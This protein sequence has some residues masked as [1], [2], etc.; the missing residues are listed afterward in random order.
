MCGRISGL[1]VAVALA[2]TGIATAQEI[3]IPS[4]ARYVFPTTPEVVVKMEKSNN[5]KY[6]RGKLLSLTASEIVVDTGKSSARDRE[7][8]DVGQRIGFERIESIRTTDGRLEFRSDEDFLEVSQRIS[9][10]YSSVTTEVDSGPAE[11]SRETPAP[12][13]QAPSVAETPP[14]RKPP[15]NGLGNGGFGGLKNL[16]KPKPADSTSPATD[17]DKMVEVG[18]SPP[19]TP[20]PPASA[21]SGASEVLLCSNCTKEIP[22]SAIKTGVCPH[23]QI[24]FSNL[25]IPSSN[26]APD[27][28][29]PKPGTPGSTTSGAFAP[30]SNV[31]SVAP[32]TNPGYQVTQSNGFSIDSIPNWA[33]GG[34]FVLLVLVGWH[35]VFN[36]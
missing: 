7:L 32:T 5:L 6:V 24:A 18:E 30:T 9:A 16:P 11:A 26:A 35:L 23:C 15:V 8:G 28:F 33:K 20:T 10:S 19:P 12:V 4:R 3:A 13:E 22:A 1:V 31:P 34:L 14:P 29:S 25:A 36:R 21:T 17:P 2:W 27:P